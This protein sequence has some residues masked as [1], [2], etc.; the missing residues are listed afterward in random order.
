[1]LMTRKRLGRSQGVARVAAAWPWI[2]LVAL[3]SVVLSAPV[4]LDRWR[5][6]SFKRQEDWMN[7]YVRGRETEKHH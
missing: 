5:H 3:S 7:A 4:V 6:R 1:M 2:G